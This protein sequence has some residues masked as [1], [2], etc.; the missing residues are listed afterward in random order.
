MEA[1]GQIRDLS[2]YLCGCVDP[3]DESPR[4]VHLTWNMIMKMPTLRVEIL[5]AIRLTQ[6]APAPDDRERIRGRGRRGPRSKR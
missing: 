5:A 1:T 6:V 2:A 3:V 4:H